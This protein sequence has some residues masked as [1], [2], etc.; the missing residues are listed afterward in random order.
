MSTYTLT[1][2]L[3]DSLAMGMCVFDAQNRAV[4]WNEH[5]L[6]FFP[7]H[8]D[9]IHVGEPY[10]DNL[11]RFYRLRLP[12]EQ[13]EH[14]ERFVLDGVRRHQEQVRAY[15]FVHRGRKLRVACAPQPNGDRIRVWQDL[16]SI[17]FAL[18]DLGGQQALA[19]LT[20][21]SPMVEA[22][23]V[24]DQLSDG[25]AIHDE[26]GRIIFANDR[27]VAIYGLRTQEDALGKTLEDIVLSNWARAGEKVSQHLLFDLH[28][29][30]KDSIHFMGIPFEVPLAGHRWV[31]T[32]LSSGPGEQSCSCHADV[33]QEKRAISEMVQL[34]KRLLLE[35]H[36][37]ALTG[38]LNRRG[39][40]PLLQQATESPGEH[41][42]LFIDLDGFK[43]V[44]DTA[45]H[46]KGDVVLC[47]VAAVLQGCVRSGDALARI[48]GDEF[49]LLLSNCPAKQAVA[50]A[51]KMV[52]VVRSTPLTI[53]GQVFH[54]GASVGVRSFST[55]ADSADVLLNDADTACYAAKRKGRGRVAMFSEIATDDNCQNN[56]WKVSEK[57]QA[58]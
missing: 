44:N 45:G 15:M 54:V 25:I 24:F 31:R 56:P 29:A 41:A 10:E 46:A 51:E 48:G 14:L 38:L 49:V 32:T 5:F 47:K 55:R 42:L 1:A 35:S 3:L 19:P 43:S 6:R 33:T 11:R 50:V 36:R 20:G 12:A 26:H 27:F 9:H 18:L 58:S 40:M 17:E 21:A 7:E 28:T 4:L 13:H 23:R 30:L 53:D 39:L 8:A 57:H 16:S 52:Q 34:N 22:L 37:D 2:S